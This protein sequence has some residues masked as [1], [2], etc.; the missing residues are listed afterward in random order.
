MPWQARLRSFRRNFLQRAPSIGEW[1]TEWRESAS[2]SRARE[3]PEI[4]WMSMVLQRIM[5]VPRREE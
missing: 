1:R 5:A 3:L 4:Y 2:T